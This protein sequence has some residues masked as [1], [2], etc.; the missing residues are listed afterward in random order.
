MLQQISSKQLVDGM[1]TLNNVGEDV[2]CE[3]CQYGKSHRLPFKRSSNQRTMM[4]ELV[5]IVSMGPKRTPSYSG[6]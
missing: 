6:H 2:I 3:G 1:P 5:H 4:F